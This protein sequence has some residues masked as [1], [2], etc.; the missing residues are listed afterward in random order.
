MTIKCTI[1]YNK[2]NVTIRLQCMRVLFG[3]VPLLDTYM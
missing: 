1:Q 3:Y 2:L